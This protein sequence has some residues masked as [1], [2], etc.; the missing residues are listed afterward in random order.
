LR[1]CL[2]HCE[3]RWAGVP[4]RLRFRPLMLPGF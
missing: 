1:R 3:F 4:W 2:D